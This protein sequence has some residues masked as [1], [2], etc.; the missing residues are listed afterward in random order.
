MNFVHI[1]GELENDAEVIFTSKDNK[2]KF[3]QFIIKV[4]IETKS[5]RVLKKIDR[6]LI[7]AWSNSDDDE[8]LLHKNAVVEIKGKVKSYSK[9]DDPT[10]LKNEIFARKIIYIN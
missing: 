6:I 10:K 2:R 8:F 5:R 9:K 7:K 4:P 3:Y 1:I